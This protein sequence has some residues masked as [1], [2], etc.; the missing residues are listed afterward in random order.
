M[1][2]SSADDPYVGQS[3]RGRAPGWPGQDLEILDDNNKAQRNMGLSVTAARG[4][5]SCEIALYGL[6]HN[7]ATVTR[8]LVLEYEVP[9]SVRERIKRITIEAA[10]VRRAAAKA[11]GQII[12]EGMEPGENRWL[13]VTFTPPTGRPG[14]IDVV[15]IFEMAGA[16]AVNGF[17]LGT[18]LGSPREA[19]GHAIERHRSV[20]TRMQHGRGID[21]AQIEADAAAAALRKM[22]TPARWVSRLQDRWDAIEEMFAAAA[23]ADDP[24]S[25]TAAAKK[26]RSALTK[27]PVDALVC[28][29]ALLERTDLTLTLHQL[30]VGDRADILQTARWQAE[31]FARPP[32]NKDPAGAVLAQTAETFVDAYGARRADHD[33]YT[34]MLRA[35]PG[36]L[37]RTRQRRR[38]GGTST[39]SH[40]ARGST[41]R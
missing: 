36:P 19:L 39:A 3:L 11:R 18:R 9:P 12:L 35:E 24:L 31:L 5:E 27:P 2:I 10:G 25:V 34:A 13:G 32:L 20:F 38:P 21:G 30:A 14:E 4:V 29:C 1:E 22:P 28:L 26:V 7:A 6:V 37:Q 33:D 23:G 41:R 40:P 16:A 15:H 17:S 8:D